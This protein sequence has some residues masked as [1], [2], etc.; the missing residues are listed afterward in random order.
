MGRN[1]RGIDAIMRLGRMAALAG[2]DDLELI[3]RRHHRAGANGELA[4]GDA[5][6][7]VHAVNLIDA[8]AVHHAIG[9]HLAPPTATLFGG[10]KDHHGGAVKVARLGQVFGRAHQ[11]GRMPV[12]ATGMHLARG[13]RGILR[14]GLLMNRQRI[15]IGA[16]PNHPA[17]GVRLALDHRHHPGAA[18]AFHHLVTANGTAELGHLGGGAVHIEQQLGV[19]V[20]IVTDRGQ[21]GQHLG[22]AVL[23]RH[24]G[25]PL[26][27]SF[28]Q[29]HARCKP[30][31]PGDLTKASGETPPRLQRQPCPDRA[32][33]IPR[34]NGHTG[35]YTGHQRAQDGQVG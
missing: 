32:E 30:R 12:M 13:F 10:L 16:Q 20:E 5:G 3:R 17:L 26:A 34:R 15:H 2:D 24:G 35:Q 23:G 14:P 29:S 21:L 11:H 27:D 9:A 18:N 22:K 6:H 31:L 25:T 7:I 19:F 33:H 1:N 8:P 4:Q 28:G